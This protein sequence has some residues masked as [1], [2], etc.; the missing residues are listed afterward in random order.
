[1]APYSY[2]GALAVAPVVCALLIV[3]VSTAAVGVNGTILE[4]TGGPRPANRVVLITTVFGAHP[5][6]VPVFLKTAAHS[7]V[8]VFLIGDS[9]A[10]SGLPPNVRQ[11]SMSWEHLVGLASTMFDGRP[12][13]LLMSAMRYKVVDLKP[14][15]G[16]LFREYIAAYEFW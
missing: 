12:L 2:L 7:G 1:M 15:F 10:I 6:Y 16:F 3:M 14:A 9:D 8:D 4:S 5:P 13:P 11:I